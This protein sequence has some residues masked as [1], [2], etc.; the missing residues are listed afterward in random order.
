MIEG[1]HDIMLES[2]SET[3]EKFAH[4]RSDYDSNEIINFLYGTIKKQWKEI[5]KLFSSDDEDSSVQVQEV[6][7]NG[8]STNQYNLNYLM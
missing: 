7:F 1:L 2:Y 3:L 8:K 5:K 6:K 4:V